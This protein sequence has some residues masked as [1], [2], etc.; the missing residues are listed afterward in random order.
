MPIP[1]GASS[2]DWACGPEATTRDDGSDGAQSTP[3]RQSVVENCLHDLAKLGK[4]LGRRLLSWGKHTADDAS[5]IGA[6]GAVAGQL[7]S[8]GEL[9]RRHRN[10]A[11]EGRRGKGEL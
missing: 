5:D 8:H 3:G 4:D 11:A 7:T 2:S 10:A 9:D 1:G 6:A